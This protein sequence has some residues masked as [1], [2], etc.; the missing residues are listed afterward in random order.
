MSSTKRPWP[1]RKRRSSTRRTDAPIPEPAVCLT[2]SALP[3]F[4]S[5]P[6]IALSRITRDLARFVCNQFPRQAL[7][8]G[9]SDIGGRSCNAH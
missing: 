2:G 9:L 6:D 1:V 7:I 8:V 4:A 3:C 5:D